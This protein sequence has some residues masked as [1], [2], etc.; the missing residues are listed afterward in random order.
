MQTWEQ[1]SRIIHTLSNASVIAKGQKS[2]GVES[3]PT[4]S[5]Y[6]FRTGRYSTILNRNN[7]SAKPRTKEFENRHTSYTENE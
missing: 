6:Q 2:E 1:W 5:S 3:K 4:N 7:I